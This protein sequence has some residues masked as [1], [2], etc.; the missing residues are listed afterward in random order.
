MF[1][2]CLMFLVFFLSLSGSFNALITSAAADGTTVTF[3]WRFWTVSLTVT[4]RPFH[5]LAVS[6]AIS[7]PIF[8]GERPSGP[9]FGASELAAPTSPPVTRTK[10]STTWLGSNFG[11]ILA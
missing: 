9:I 1:P 3:A 2:L 7:S 5:S 6:L 11:G 8:L 10:T 4:R